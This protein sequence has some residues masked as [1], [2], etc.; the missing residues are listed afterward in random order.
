MAGMFSFASTPAASASGAKPA[1]TPLTGGGAMPA[2]GI[3]APAAGQ[4]QPLAAL[5]LFQTP[6]PAA[7]KPAATPL[8][9]GTLGVGL[10]FGTGAAGA[11]GVAPKK[12]AFLA[13]CGSKTLEQVYRDLQAELERHENDFRNACAAVSQR[14][15]LLLLHTEQLHQLKTHLDEAQLAQQQLVESINML[16][17]RMKSDPES[18]EVLIQRLENPSQQL[19]A[20]CI[21]APINDERT[22]RLTK[23]ADVDTFLMSMEEIASDAMARINT[24]HE[25]STD[26]TLL[27]R[28]VDILNYHWAILQWADTSSTTISGQLR[29]IATL[30]EQHKMNMERLFGRSF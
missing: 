24:A 21:P 12:Y 28:I 29:E 4:P 17:V 26:L 30:L 8:T 5:P 6:T 2:W 3:P 25:R 13:D 27:N 19:L 15:K 20:E 1:S 10:A 18:L 7:S 23:V 16:M 11:G 14:D 22:S 9:G